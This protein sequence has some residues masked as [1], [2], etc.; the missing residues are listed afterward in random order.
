MGKI[1]NKKKKY[2]KRI[3]YIPGCSIFF[4][5]SLIDL[6]GFLPED[7]FMFCE[8]VDFSYKA[9]QNGI[10]LNIN[11]ESVLIHKEG[12][13]VKKNKIAF[14]SFINRIKLSKK[15]FP[16]NLIY[17]YIGILYQILKNIILLRWSFAYKIIINLK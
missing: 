17:V 15:Y 7:Y 8:D 14:I 16:Q 4:H 9:K 1:D 6:I 13:S 11:Q 10:Y 5:N 3:D 12:A 2:I